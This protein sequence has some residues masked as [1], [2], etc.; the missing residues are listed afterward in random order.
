M[1]CFFAGFFHVFRHEES[2]ALAPL[3]EALSLCTE[4]GM[5]LFLANST[6]L[7]GR[8]LVNQGKAYEGVRHIRE[9][10]TSLDAMEAKI[11]RS[12]FLAYQAEGYAALGQCEAGLS[13]LAQALAFV[14]TQDERF[15]EAELYRL[16]G[17]LT[18][19]SNVEG[20]TPKVE[21]AEEY[22]Q[23]AIEIAH[24]Q[25]AKSF[26]LRAAMSLARLW[27]HH[28]KRAE[29]HKLLSEIYRWFTEG[30][31]T[32]DLQEAKALLDELRD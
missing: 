29:A 4:Y 7:Q 2:Q 20:S 25:H 13:R 21:E 16:K 8:V 30:F 9:A 27:Q 24:S 23:Q 15:Y 6:A 31:D 11:A 32:K 12:A 14:E 3:T 19:Q 18:L 28:G 26:E 1:A 17:T 5:P 10:L 22:F